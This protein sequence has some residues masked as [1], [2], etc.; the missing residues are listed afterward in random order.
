MKDLVI[1]ECLVVTSNAFAE[2]A[3]NSR[4]QTV[5]GNGQAAGGYNRNTGT[6]WTSQTNQNGGRTT[7]T[8][9]GGEAMTMNGKGVVHGPGG[10]TCYRS[11]NSHGCN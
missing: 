1:L 4:G 2:C 8:N 10:T 9:R 7:Q 3:T 5:C 6:A 11:A